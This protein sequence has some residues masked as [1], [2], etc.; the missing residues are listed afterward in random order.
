MCLFW[1]CQ[2]KMF[3][4]CSGVTS[5]CLVRESEGQRDCGKDGERVSQDLPCVHLYQ[6]TLRGAGKRVDEVVAGGLVGGSGLG[7]P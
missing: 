7:S 6:R 5:M 3:P 2:K 4:L 1:K